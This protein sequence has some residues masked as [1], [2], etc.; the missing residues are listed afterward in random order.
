MLCFFELTIF[1]PF[2]IV[3]EKFKEQV[4]CIGRWFRGVR[5]EDHV[6][7]Y[8]VGEMIPFRAME[9]GADYEM[10]KLYNEFFKLPFLCIN[11]RPVGTFGLI[12]YAMV[13]HTTHLKHMLN[14]F[15]LI[16]F[17]D[18]NGPLSLRKAEK[19]FKK[20]FRYNFVVTKDRETESPQDPYEVTFSKVNE[21]EENKKIEDFL[22]HLN[23]KSFKNSE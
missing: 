19:I 15:K 17:A 10:R 9:E 8:D 5:I 21:Q 1:L 20:G 12:I 16:A 23:Q 2:P 4:K 14:F 22:T 7:L 6:Y 11:V 18:K 3:N 13:H